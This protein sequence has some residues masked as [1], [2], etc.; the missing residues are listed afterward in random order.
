MLQ[1]L[2]WLSSSTGWAVGVVS[3]HILRPHSMGKPSDD[4]VKMLSQHV[5]PS[6][7]WHEGSVV[8]AMDRLYMLT[9]RCCGSQGP[10]DRLL[11]YFLSTY[12]SQAWV[13]PQASMKSDNDLHGPPHAPTSQS[14]Q[15]AS[16]DRDSTLMQRIL[17]LRYPPCNK[18]FIYVS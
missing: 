7:P 17:T 18:T 13:S 8:M 9:I 16:H 4:A 5:G 11:R 3:C 6:H 2:P 10:H 14:S 12:Q 15:P 1:S